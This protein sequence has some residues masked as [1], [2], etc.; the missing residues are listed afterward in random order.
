ME[1]LSQACAVIEWPL[2]QAIV[3]DEVM[4]R[5]SA[6][7]APRLSWLRRKAKKNARNQAIQHATELKI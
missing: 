3:N 7:A 5:I 1:P 4:L 2:P 6:M